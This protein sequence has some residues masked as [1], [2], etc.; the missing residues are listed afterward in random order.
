MSWKIDE[1]SFKEKFL[2]FDKLRGAVKSIME[3]RKMEDLDK[4]GLREWF[5]YKCKQEENDTIY[6]LSNEQR[7]K[8]FDDFYNYCLEDGEILLSLMG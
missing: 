8:L 4:G 7:I 6:R 2:D 1:Q 5:L 3:K